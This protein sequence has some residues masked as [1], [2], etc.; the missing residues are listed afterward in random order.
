MM[1]MMCVLCVVAGSIVVRS[2]YGGTKD[3]KEAK[4]LL[5]LGEPITTCTCTVVLCM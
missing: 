4:K 1:L 3:T 2:S 5:P